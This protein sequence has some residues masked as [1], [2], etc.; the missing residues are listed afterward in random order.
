MTSLNVIKAKG[1]ALVGLANHETLCRAMAAS[2][3]VMDPQISVKVAT[4]KICGHCGKL[5]HTTE[6]CRDPR[7]KTEN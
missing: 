1:T 7:A 5:G 6:V 3:V 2:P 4:L